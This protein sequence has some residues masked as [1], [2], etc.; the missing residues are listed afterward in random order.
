MLRNGVR[1]KSSE[2]FRQVQTSCR[3]ARCDATRTSRRRARESVWRATS[4]EARHAEVKSPGRQDVKGHVRDTYRHWTSHEMQQRLPNCR[5][6]KRNLT[7]MSA[8]HLRI[9]PGCATVTLRPGVERAG[10]KICQNPHCAVN[11]SSRAA[12]WPKNNP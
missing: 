8:T 10:G 1:S 11:R 9:G 3:S 4:H 7:L 6:T 5:V 2:G 12:R